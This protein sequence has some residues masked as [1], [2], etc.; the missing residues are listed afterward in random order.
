MSIH[1]I[2]GPVTFVA[3]CEVCDW[4][5]RERR[6]NLVSLADYDRH[7]LTTRHGEREERATMMLAAARYEEDAVERYV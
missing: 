4:V 7:I 2:N 6:D 3:Y 5:G 1:A